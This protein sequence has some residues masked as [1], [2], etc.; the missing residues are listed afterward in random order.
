VVKFLVL[1][2]SRVFFKIYGFGSHLM[3]IKKTAYAKEENRI[4]QKEDPKKHLIIHPII[5]NRKGF[6]RTKKRIII[7]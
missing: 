1:F 4:S 5:V 2:S 6:R 3:N 7:A